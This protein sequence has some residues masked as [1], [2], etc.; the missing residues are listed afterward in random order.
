MTL[1]WKEEE[2]FLS[3]Y[4]TFTTDDI[5]IEVP[6]EHVKV[7]S[8]GN[9]LANVI[10]PLMPVAK[11]PVIDNLK[12]ELHL[13]LK[14]EVPRTIAAIVNNGMRLNALFNYFKSWSWFKNWIPTVD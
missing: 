9:M 14:E 2:G 10:G 11:G 4:S 7:R 6:R 5:V 3:N 8:H 1:H 13:W 12:K